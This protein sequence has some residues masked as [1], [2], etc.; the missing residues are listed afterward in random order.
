MPSWLRPLGIA[1]YGLNLVVSFLIVFAVGGL[2]RLGQTVIR[3]IADR[4]GSTTDPTA[5]SRSGG[6][7][8]KEAKDGQS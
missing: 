6:N 3:F 2:I 5:R 8:N 1:I 7:S 4:T